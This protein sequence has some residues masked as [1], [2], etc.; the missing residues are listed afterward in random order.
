MAAYTSEEEFHR[1][2]NE[3]GS[4]VEVA[5]R[6][7]MAVT[8]VYKRKARME[9][10][11]WEFNTHSPR[12]PGAGLGRFER[13]YPRLISDT[14]RDGIV[15]VGSD[16][17]YWPDQEPSTAHKA[18]V[19]FAKELKPTAIVLNGD[20][21]DFAAI[22]RH[23]R[24]GW[25]TAPTPL[26][27]INAACDRVSEIEDAASG[28]KL[29]RTPGNHCLRLEGF[30]SNRVPELKGLP[31][32]RLDYYLPK[33]SAAWAIHFNNSIWITHR[34]NGGVNAPLQNTIKIG[35]SVCTG[36]LHCQDVRPYTDLNGTRWGVDC[37]QLADPDWPQ[38]EYV[39]GSVPNWRS[40]FAVFTFK[41]YQLLPPEL[42]TVTGP[43]KV[44][45]R[46]VEANV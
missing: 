4:P 46:G 38:F 24:I 43:G 11:G 30:I 2:Y 45:F 33:W 15:I 29:Y 26:E 9:G 25:S 35:H 37:G 31:G 16:A 40:G 8:A 23:H 28:A 20:I 12:N 5:R 44:Y 39:E 41:D 36:H 10:A 42:V 1:I 27:E 17:H 32:S 19:W 3:L 14:I 34:L 13:A 6:I 21:F 18:L 7:G 22:S